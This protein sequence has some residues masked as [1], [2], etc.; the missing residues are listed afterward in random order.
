ME[1]N[2][3][4]IRETLN[5]LGKIQTRHIESFDTEIMPDLE[6]QVIERNTELSRLKK[7][8]GKFITDA[9]LDHDANI[10]SMISFF[11]DRIQTLADQNRVLKKKVATHKDR[12]QESM[13]KLSRG[14]QVIGSYGAPASVSNRPR[15]IHLTN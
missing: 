13:K 12:L 5:R 4:R 2:F 15:A 11:T 14:K 3:Q 7:N 9:G 6:R 10:E 8:V 1:K